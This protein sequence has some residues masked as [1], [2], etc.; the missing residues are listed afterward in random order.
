MLEVT[1]VAIVCLLHIYFF[2]LESFLWTTPHG[3]KVFGMT[4]EDAQR[5]KKL[6]LNQ[7]VYNAFV[8]AG[9]IWALIHPVGLVASQ[10]AAFILG[11]VVI[12]G[13]VGGL[14]VSKKIFFIQALPALIGILFILF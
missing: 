12:A 11:F 7:G 2:I 3:L 9:L 6:A 14:T 8:A 4:Q 13:V 5:T 10:I 1:F